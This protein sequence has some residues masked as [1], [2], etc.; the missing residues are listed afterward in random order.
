MNMTDVFNGIGSFFQWTFTFMKSFGNGPNLVFW[1]IIGAL[2]ITW[3]RMQAKYNK[4]A[5][6]KGTLQ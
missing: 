1:L 5:K 6:D 4:E 2:I 3:F